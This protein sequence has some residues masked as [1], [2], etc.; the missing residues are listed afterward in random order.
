MTYNL[1]ILYNDGNI[2]GK[3]PLCE[4]C[5]VLNVS[6]PVHCILD[7]KSSK[8]EV[9]IVFLVDSYKWDSTISVLGE[10]EQDVFEKYVLPLIGESSYEILAAIK[11]PDI[12]ESEMTTKNKK[13]C[14]QHLDATFNEVKAKLII[15]FGNLAFQMITHKSGLTKKRGSSVYYGEIPVVPTYHLTSVGLE[16][17]MVSLFQQDIL[18]S[19][20]K[21]VLGVTEELKLEYKIIRSIPEL[22]S[23]SD[24]LWNTKDPIA[25]DIETGGFDFKKTIITTIAIAYK[26]GDKYKQIIIPYKHKESPFKDS[27]EDMAFIKFFLN[28]TFIRVNKK[29]LQNGKFDMKFLLEEGIW[30]D[31]VWDTMIMSHLTDENKPKSL[32][33]MVKEH[34]SEFLE[35]L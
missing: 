8:K 23:Y 11:C 31:N 21:Y 2:N 6:K 1:N 10:L 14:R 4:G 13:I 3:N 34:Y 33:D 27:E 15:P 16:P 18:N 19:Y 29:I 5:S 9:D 32:L 28:A 30:I 24:I 7:Y 22:K 35:E 17:K 12:K 20:N 26:D 25:V